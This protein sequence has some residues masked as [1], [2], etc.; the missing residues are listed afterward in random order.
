M[1][2]SGVVSQYG[3]KLINLF[4]MCKYIPLR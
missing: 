4:L 2:K 3:K 1:L